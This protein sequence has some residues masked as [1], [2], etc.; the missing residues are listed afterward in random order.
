M[1]LLGK[2]MRIIHVIFLS[3]TTWAHAQRDLN[4]EFGAGPPSINVVTEYYSRLNASFALEHG[5]GEIAVYQK[6]VSDGNTVFDKPVLIYR[7]DPS[8]KRFYSEQNSWTAHGGTMRTRADYG[9]SVIS[10]QHELYNYPDGAY[11][12]S[13]YI[14]KYYQIDDTLS[15]TIRLRYRFDALIDYA[16]EGIVDSRAEWRKRL[17]ASSAIPLTTEIPV[18]ANVLTIPGST[19]LFSYDCIIPAAYPIYRDPPAGIIVDRLDRPIQYDT[20]SY[21]GIGETGEVFLAPYKS[22]RLSYHGDGDVLQSCI[23]YEHFDNEAFGA[24]VREAK[25]KGQRPKFPD[26]FDASCIF[27]QLEAEEFRYGIP[28]RVTISSAKHPDSFT[29]YRAVIRTRVDD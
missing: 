13:K 23:A 8:G 27:Y 26:C 10:I 1:V 4:V 18:G 6:K 2:T 3:I 24:I 22:I 14:S 16:D 15:R 19:T 21:L 5:I 20:H 28:Q 25:S 9:D 12:D 11:T 17:K 29:E 7:F